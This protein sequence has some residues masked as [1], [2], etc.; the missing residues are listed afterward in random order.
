MSRKNGKKFCLITVIVLV[1]IVAI[2]LCVLQ[3]VDEK[4]SIME[5]LK[6]STHRIIEDM[7]AADVS[8]EQYSEILCRN[9]TEEEVKR[10]RELEAQF[11]LVMYNNADSAQDI[12]LP[13]GTWLLNEDTL[14]FRL[15]LDKDGERYYHFF[16]L[17]NEEIMPRYRDHW[18]DSFYS[19]ETSMTELKESYR[20]YRLVLERFYIE[21][22]SIIPGRIGIY[23]VERTSAEGFK[24]GY[25]GPTNVELVDEWEYEVQGA[26]ELAC[27]ELVDELDLYN[28]TDI[29]LAYTCN[30]VEYMVNRDCTLNG[31]FISPEE[32]KE[33]LEDLV[34]ETY[35]LQDR[36]LVGL[37]KY[38]IAKEIYNC[39]MLG[40]EV[41]AVVCETNMLYNA[42]IYLWMYVAV[43]L[44]VDILV[45]LGIAAIVIA[46]KK[47]KPKLG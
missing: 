12:L 46:L 31:K 22:G 37:P 16:D 28:V 24:P 13:D 29:S 17:E 14:Y 1:V 34:T 41:T 3:V 38:H 40:G 27:Y 2:E 42:Y 9:L 6:R 30:G 39:D 15:G 20:Y 18:E 11:R 5:V 19:Y 45:A 44:F 21:D 32:R 36:D 47:R 4:M 26:E 33:L 10:Q 25:D 8:T 43:V 7:D 35:A 23:K